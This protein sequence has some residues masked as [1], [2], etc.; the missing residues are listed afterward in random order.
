MAGTRPRT[1]KTP[2]AGHHGS[3]T[4]GGAAV[5]PV[6]LAR[7]WWHEI[8]MS[9]FY[10]PIGLAV[11]AMGLR[12]GSPL[13]AMKANPGLAR[14]GLF[15]DS[16]QDFFDLFPDQSPLVPLSV[17]LE[18]AFNTRQVE[19]RFRRFASELTARQGAFPGRFVVKPND[20]VR[21]QNIR[22]MASLEEILR[23]WQGRERGSG[24]WLLQEY[25][26][27]IEIAL[28]YN[29]PDASMPGRILSMTMKH[30]FVVTGDGAST[31]GQLIEQADADRATRRRVARTSHERI[32]MILPDGESLDLI[33]VRNHHLGAT[34][35]DVSDR[36]TPELEAALCAALDQVSGF[37]Y[38]RLDCRVPDL[39]SLE[40]GE[41]IRALEVNALYSEPV[42]AYDP[43]YT[44][45]DAY[46]IFLRHWREA[47]RTG[48]RNG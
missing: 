41:G 26:G 33:P 35:Q 16:K 21:G 24:N 23:F 30:G 5:P 19:A 46:G 42:N 14:G 18:G 29:Q 4:R 31:I 15:P 39:A 20:G 40:R 7:R 27:G 28:F 13:I 2:P 8:P 47:I 1:R 38:G 22:F 10:V 11:I 34:F 45:R 25:V 37:Q 32:A 36:I 43:K 3:T 44:L 12:H 6:Q 48:V 9:V 17:K